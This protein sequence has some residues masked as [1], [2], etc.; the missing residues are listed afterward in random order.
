L[1]YQG[2]MHRYVNFNGIKL[3][4]FRSSEPTGAV[5]TWPWPAQKGPQNPSLSGDRSG[6]QH[7]DVAPCRHAAT[8]KL[9]AQAV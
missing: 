4:A 5:V 3:T 2:G 1:G 6:P 8:E 9:V 7:P